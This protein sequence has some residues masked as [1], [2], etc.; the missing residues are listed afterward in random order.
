[1]PGCRGAAASRATTA[2]RAFAL[3]LTGT[4]DS[5]VDD[6]GD[7]RD[8]HR[9]HPVRAHPRARS[10]RPTCRS[11]SPEMHRWAVRDGRAVAAHFAI[12]TEAMLAALAA[13]A[14]ACPDCGFVWV[15]VPAAEVGPRVTRGSDAAG[16]PTATR[17]APDAAPRR[18]ARRVV[19]ARVRR[20]RP[21]R[22]DEPPRPRRRRPRRG[23]ARRSSRCTATSGSTP[24]STATSSPRWWR[25]SSSS[26]ADLFAAHVRVPRPTSSSPRPVIYAYPDRAER[27]ILWM[28]RQVVHEVEH[29]L[30][31]VERDLGA[32]APASGLHGETGRAVAGRAGDAVQHRERRR[33][34]DRVVRR[35]SRRRRRSGGTRR[36]GASAR[37][38]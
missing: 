7:L 24:A 30:G 16:R 22:A 6:R 10:G 29:H 17:A 28:G 14:E 13:P 32:V 33:D 26:A 37:A 1:M 4:I 27:T 19:G 31:D 34:R 21:R 11:T 20:A 35:R 9:G 18:R 15:D 2:W 8:R 25:P 36:R 12:D 38:A 23:H 3:A 5:Q